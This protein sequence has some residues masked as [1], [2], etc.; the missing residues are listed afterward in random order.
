MTK[1]LRNDLTQQG[2]LGNGDS[3]HGGSGQSQDREGK[4]NN[5]SKAWGSSPDT[6]RDLGQTPSSLEL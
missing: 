2:R 1:R 3:L 5:R 4:E 6:L